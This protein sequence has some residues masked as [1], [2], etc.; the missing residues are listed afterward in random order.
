MEHTYAYTFRG[1]QWTFYCVGLIGTKKLGTFCDDVK[2]RA[3]NIENG[4]NFHLCFLFT[5][6]L[7]YLI[8]P[9]KRRLAYLE[10]KKNV[11]IG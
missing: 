9:K 3:K 5:F 4:D 10:E 11:Y 1:N 2:H 6:E 7:V 8:F